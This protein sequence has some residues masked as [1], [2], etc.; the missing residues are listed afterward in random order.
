MEKSIDKVDLVYMIDDDSVIIYLTELI[1]KT[2]DFCKE[3]K[4]FTKGEDAL[5][6]IREAAE[7]GSKLPDL[8]LIDLN[9]PIFN[10]WHFLDA[11]QEIERAKDIPVFVFTSSIDPRDIEKSKTYSSIKDYI[12]KP[13]TIH[14]INKILRY[15]I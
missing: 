1:I 4:T 9:M 7:T 12:V 13:L 11:L 14:K 10:G 8:L 15:V 5:N 3:L 2:V 6:T